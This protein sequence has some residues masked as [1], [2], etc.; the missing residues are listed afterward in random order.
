[1]HPWFSLG[2]DSLVR[3]GPLSTHLSP[4]CSLVARRKRSEHLGQDAGAGTK[5]AETCS[6]SLSL[7]P[8]GI[9]AVARKIR[10]L[11]TAAEIIIVS[12]RR[13]F[14]EHAP[15]PPAG[16]SKLLQLS[17]WSRSSRPR[18]AGARRGDRGRFDSPRYEIW[19][20]CLLARTPRGEFS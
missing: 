13:K 10:R 15:P 2:E 18:G 9:A 16:R 8:Q 3:S 14:S 19:E 17:S 4:G 5:Q 6:L 1:M 11:Q 12:C 7:S 20:G